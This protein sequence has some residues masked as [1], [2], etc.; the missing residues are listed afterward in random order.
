MTY[1]LRADG[2]HVVATEPLKRINRRATWEELKLLQRCREL[3]Y[4]PENFATFKLQYKIT[5]KVNAPVLL[6][7]QLERAGRGSVAE[8]LEAATGSLGWVWL[9]DG[10]RLKIRTAEAQI[11]NQLARR[12]TFRYEDTPVSRV[13]MDLADR[14]EV[15]LHLEP[16]VLLKLPPAVARTSL[17]LQHSSIRQALNL[18]SAETGLSYEMRR[19]GL[20]V[21]LAV[22]FQ[23]GQTVAVGRRSPYVGKISIPSED[24]SYSYD[25]LLREDDL[26]EDI[27]EYRRQMIKEYIDRMRRDIAPD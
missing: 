8:M 12:V 11:A 22:D 26:P 17:V 7:Q 27:L 21:G 24:G 4:T 25:I 13:L 20:H 15:A 10:D 16:G 5:R 3:E 19:D 2:L 6:T 18:L 14:A 9:P 1:E 23:A